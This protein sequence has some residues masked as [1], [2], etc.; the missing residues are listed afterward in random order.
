MR[1]SSSIFLSSLSCF[2]CIACLRDT[3][4]SNSRFRSFSSFICTDVGGSIDCKQVTNRGVHGL[5]YLLAEYVVVTA[6]LRDIGPQRSL[7]ALLQFVVARICDQLLCR[8]GRQG[9]RWPQSHACCKR[10]GKETGN[11][12]QQRYRSR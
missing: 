10:E 6:A 1:N 8:L 4:F 5:D 9:W 12:S 7:F 3:F 11:A 2:F